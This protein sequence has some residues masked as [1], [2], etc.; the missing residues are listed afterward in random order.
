[1][2]SYTYNTIIWEVEAGGLGIHSQSWLY[3]EFK[4][5]LGYMIP[6]C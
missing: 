5:S 1:M 6:P 2:I 3:S 4:D